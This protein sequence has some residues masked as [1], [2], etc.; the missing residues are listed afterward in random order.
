[1]G[2]AGNDDQVVVA[3]Q[4]QVAI[5]ELLEG[6]L[7]P[8]VSTMDDQS[9][10]SIALEFGFDLIR[11]HGYPRLAAALVAARGRPQGAPLQHARLTL[12][13]HDRPVNFLCEGLGLGDLMFF[14]RL[15]ASRRFMRYAQLRQDAGYVEA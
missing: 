13:L 10:R 5:Q 8:M 2:P 9:A 11:R 14:G 4:P 7:K 6:R 1:M 12:V 3:S 15:M